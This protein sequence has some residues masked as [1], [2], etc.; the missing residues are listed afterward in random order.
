MGQKIDDISEKYFH[1]KNKKE[2][3]AEFLKMVEV[4]N[5]KRKKLTVKEIKVKKEIEKVILEEVK[6]KVEEIRE[7]KK[8]KKLKAAL[9]PEKPT[10]ILKIGDRVRMKDGKSIGTIDKIE[11]NK[12]VV[13]YGVFTSKVSLEELEYVQVK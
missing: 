9:E 1:N 11:K 3:I 5:S 4:E 7:V 10:V 13:N 8:E 6:V 2:L 12:A